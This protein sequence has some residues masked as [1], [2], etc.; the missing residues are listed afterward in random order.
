MTGAAGPPSGHQ[1]DLFL[2]LLGPIAARHGDSPLELGHARQRTVLAVLALEPDKPVNRSAIIDAVWNDGPPRSAANLIQTYVSR[3]RRALRPGFLAPDSVSL[4]ASEGQGYRLRVTVDQLDLLR[5]RELV[6]GAR[7]AWSAGSLDAAA[8]SFRQA[9]NLWRGDPLADL[10]ALRVYPPVVGLANEWV[11]CVI[12]YA[13]VCEALRRCDHAITHLRAAA[14]R[15]PLDERLHSRLM[16][17]LAMTGNRSGA[18]QV[19]QSLRDRLDSELGICPGAELSGSYQRILQGTAGPAV[20]GPRAVTG[21]E[22]VVPRQLPRAIPG[23]VGRAEY[24]RTLSAALD[25]SGR[26]GGSLPIFVISGPAGVGKTS[27]A[28]HWAHGIADR[29]PDGQIH[30][31]LCGFAPS[32]APASPGQ[33]IRR[34]LELFRVPAERM[35]ASLDAQLAL[36]RSLLADKHVL[37]VLD[38]ARDPEQIRALLPTGPG[39]L[40]LVTSRDSLLGLAASHGA[41]LVTLD[42]FTDAEAEEFIALG[43]L[44]RPGPDETSATAEIIRLCDRLPLALA[45]VVARAMAHQTWPLAALASELRGT[46]VRLDELDAGDATVNVRAVFSWSYRELTPAAA[47]VFRLLGLHGGPDI[48]VWAVASLAGLS[49]PGTRRLTGELAR[50]HLIT[51]HAPGR[52]AIHDLLRAYAA[53]ELRDQEEDAERR[54]ATRRLLDYYLHTAYSA[55]LAINP[56]RDALGLAPA[57]AG[58]V[59]ERISERARAN[60]WFEAEYRVLMKA[61]ELAVENGYEDYAWQIPW[62]LVNFFD[63]QGYWQDWVATHQIALSAARRSHD[64]LGQ[65]SAH[66][67]ISIV[68]VHLRSYKEAQEHL[69][70]AIT[71]NRKLGIRAGHARCLLDI[72]RTFES[73]DRYHDA[74]EHASTALSLYR[75]MGHQFGQARALNAVGWSSAHLGDARRAITC[76]TQALEIH[77]KLGNRM[78]QA[79]TLDSLGYAHTELGQHADAIRCYERALELLDRK[80]RTYQVA[81]VLA[82][83]ATSYQAAR[84]DQAAA[85]MSQEALSILRAL[86]HPEV[87]RTI[88]RFSDAGIPG[89]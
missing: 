8:A 85:L 76:C 22:A 7:S 47:R 49:L 60:D 50:V 67:H 75:E 58:A 9:L 1:P 32:G 65:A 26:Q 61:I 36:Y 84:S 54:A 31:D 10:A 38:N 12:D 69:Q 78:G 53:D 4:L 3:L 6:A 88:A 24:L 17:A 64:L 2:Q 19:Y 14:T 30:V 56:A 79:A 43:M 42:V 70:Q 15:H 34:F 44:A 27:L 74:L 81:C 51:E 45:I 87:D 41:Q 20:V 39:C 57:S 23:F 55:A 86:E 68:Y 33:V 66:Q 48:S 62:T 73:Q 63:Q 59:P 40:T 46:P 25:Q 77:G 37:I 28:L 29:F 13:D 83:L 52:F 35:P 21:H 80:E 71:L 11:T 89:H 72:A 16:I 5:F 18:L 82:N